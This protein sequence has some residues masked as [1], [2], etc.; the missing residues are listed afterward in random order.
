MGRI[1][2]FGE[3]FELDEHLSVSL[4]VADPSN[5]P[6]LKNILFVF[7]KGDNCL[8]RVRTIVKP[9]SNC[10]VKS[11]PFEQFDLP[12]GILLRFFVCVHCAQLANVLCGTNGG[13]K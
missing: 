5:G 7:T 9:F 4:V 11:M 2:L 1:R 3:I 10:V 12:F 13:G 8:L 6:F